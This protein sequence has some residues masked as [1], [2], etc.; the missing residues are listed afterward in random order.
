[1]IGG[2]FY[3]ELNIEASK[4]LSN[5]LTLLKSVLGPM[6]AGC[7]TANQHTNS[8]VNFVNT[9]NLDE[10]VAQ[11]FSLES[12]GIKEE[13]SENLSLDNFQKT[14]KFNGERYEVSLPWKNFPPNLSSNFGLS[15]GRLKST[16][17]F[18]RTKPELFN[19][20]N[21]I[22]QDQLKGN[23]IEVTDNN[24]FKGHFIPHQP[25]VR[26]DK[27]KVRIVYDAS[28]RVFKNSYSLNDCLH[29]GPL[30]LNSLTGILLRFRIHSIVILA[31]IEKAFLQVSLQESDRDYTKLLW[32]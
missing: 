14:I 24:I 30:L 28:A 31:D 11:F 32:V 4:K 9:T 10:S 22:I 1:M 19:Q 2:D 26:V 25:V 3:Y 18:L 29:S 8:V 13:H 27:S 20:Y 23:I 21:Q 6:V 15:L 16:I 17:R 12:V 7:M 5:G